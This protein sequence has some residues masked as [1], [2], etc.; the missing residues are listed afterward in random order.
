MISV[1]EVQRDCFSISL[2]YRL[3]VLLAFPRGII[4]LL[5]LNCIIFALLDI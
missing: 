1:G 2:P 3:A 5:L 4:V